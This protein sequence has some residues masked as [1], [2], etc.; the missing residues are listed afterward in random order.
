MSDTDY[1]NDHM[2]GFDSDG[3]P[4]F[5]STGNGKGGWDGY[6]DVN[7]AFYHLDRRR[8]DNILHAIKMAHKAVEMLPYYV[9][10]DNPDD[11]TAY[12][13]ELV[14]IAYGWKGIHDIFRQANDVSLASGRI[15]YFIKDYFIFIHPEKEVLDVTFVREREFKDKSSTVGLYIK[16]DPEVDADK[17]H[18]GLVS[19]LQKF[20]VALAFYRLDRLT[21][22]QFDAYLT[23]KISIRDIHLELEY[24]NKLDD[25]SDINNKLIK[26]KIIEL[27]TEMEHFGSPGYERA[28]MDEI[29]ILVEISTKDNL[30]PTFK[31][32]PSDCETY[33]L[34]EISPKGDIISFHIMSSEVLKEKYSL[35]DG[36]YSVPLLDLIM[37][38]KLSDFKYLYK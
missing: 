26:D 25:G 3:L 14:G 17:W 23:H 37:A 33:H 24:L 27:V 29:K 21:K 28:N 38:S 32:E 34:Y 5:L 18:F 8:L 6:G 16:P 12:S 7:Y 10:D 11:L 36:I 22:D 15:D 30:M 1:I 35:V 4:N 31:I 20:K 13:P 19:A 2:G 9:D